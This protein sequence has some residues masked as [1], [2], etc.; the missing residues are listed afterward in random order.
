MLEEV[1]VVETED[2]EGDVLDALLVAMGMIHTK[3]G[4]RLFIH[5]SEKINMFDH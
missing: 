1:D 4:V 3:V 2:A 5:K